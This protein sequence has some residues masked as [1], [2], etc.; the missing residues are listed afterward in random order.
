MLVDSQYTEVKRSLILA[1]GGMRVAYQA[2]VLLALEES[3]TKFSHVDGTS[4]GIFN[5]AMIASGLEAK[6]I[7]KRW[8]SLKFKHFVSGRKFKD[9]LK[10]FFMTGYADADN[11]RSK[12]FPHLGIDT[13]KIQKNTSVNATFNL[14]NFSNKTI[15]SIGNQKIKDDHLIAGV[16]LPMLM[17]ALR[18]GEDWYIDA[19]WIKDAN[20]LEGVRQQSQELWLVWAIGN[21]RSYLPGAFNQYVHMIEMSANGGLI[22]EYQQI[23]L[24]NQAIVHKIGEY[25]QKEPIKLFVIK[26]PEPL[27]LDPDLFFN[28]INTRELINIGYENAKAHLAQVPL[29]HSPMDKNATRSMESGSVLSFRATFKGKLAWDS[30]DSEISYYLYFRFKE[31]GEE[32][33]LIA[34]SSIFIATLNGEFPVYDHQV[35]KFTYQGDNI[36]EI[37]GKLVIRGE[38]YH[39]IS[40]I[41][42]HPPLEMILGIGFK[43]LFLTITKKQSNVQVPILQG[44]LFQSISDRLRACYFTSVKA[45]KG[46]AGSMGKR[47]QMIQK[48]VSHEI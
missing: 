7:A 39:I 9:Y 35:K 17:P 48:F 2:G 6:E 29:Q 26:S 12:V 45:E 19:V 18:I 22:E 21:S 47:Y 42:L 31:L 43:Q 37:Q 23:K 36:C 20:L 24:I 11:I 13:D 41:K 16:S 3:G 4:G 5:T 25:A 32:Q 28:K 15:E 1:G 8:R 14:C 44:R 40:M 27:P 34:V 33:K 10:P 38:E 30:L 46:K